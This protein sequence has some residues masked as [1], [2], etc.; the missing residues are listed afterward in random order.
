[1]SVSTILEH[2]EH[3][4]FFI[5]YFSTGFLPLILNR[6]RGEIAEFH[7]VVSLLEWEKRNACREEKRE[8]F[9]K[10]EWKKLFHFP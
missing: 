3:F 7:S 1:M 2:W 10:I 4:P 5:F 9:S 6:S 8:I